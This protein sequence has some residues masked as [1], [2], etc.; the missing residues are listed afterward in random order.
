MGEGMGEGKYRLMTVWQIITL[1]CSNS[2]GRSGDGKWCQN[3]PHKITTYVTVWERKPADL[4]LIAGLFMLCLLLGILLLELSELLLFASEPDGPSITT[5][6]RAWSWLERWCFSEYQQKKSFVK[7]KTGFQYLLFILPKRLFLR[8]VC[9]KF[10]S[11]A[12]IYKTKTTSTKR[13]L[14]YI[15]STQLKVLTLNMT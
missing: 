12:Y 11:S 14:H 8:P 9:F 7:S 1:C 5:A 2:K 10:L 4:M 15:L 6:S 13:S 3:V